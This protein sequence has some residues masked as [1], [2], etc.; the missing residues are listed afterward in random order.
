MVVGLV[1]RT[2]PIELDVEEDDGRVASFNL[3]MFNLV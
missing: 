3:E 2:V 1:V